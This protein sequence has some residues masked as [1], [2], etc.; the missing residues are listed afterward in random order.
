MR[1]TLPALA[2]LLSAPAVAA[3][4]R[5]RSDSLPRELVVAL[6]GGAFGGSRN[7]DVQAGLADDSL[8]A[9]LFRDA[10]LLGFADYRVTSSTVAYFPYAPQATLDTI[11]ARL[12]A[13]G[14]KVPAQPQDTMRGFVQSYSSMPEVICRDNSV[15]MPT[16]MIRTLN[17]SLAV[18]SRHR[19]GG[20]SSMCNRDQSS[21]MRYRNP[22]QNTPLPALPAPPGMMSRGSGMGGSPDQENGVTMSTSLVGPSNSQVILAHYEAAFIAAGWRKTEQAQSKSIGVATFEITDKGVLWY[23]SF[24][25]MAPLDDAAQVNLALRRK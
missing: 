12:L 11:K 1:L 13:A 21:A 8:P 24:V 10:L 4:Q 3:Q 19:E 18:I 15:I 16:V 14:W 6:L 25:V 9:A 5:P 23:C 17:R 2:L 7:V 22:V 20:M